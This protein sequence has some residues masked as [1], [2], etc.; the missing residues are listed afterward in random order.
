M[1]IYNLRA[2]INAILRRD[3]HLR[4]SEAPL[5]VY[6]TTTDTAIRDAAFLRTYAE[7]IR[8]GNELL[9]EIPNTRAATLEGIAQRI[10]ARVGQDHDVPSL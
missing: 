10:E 3:K 4:A 5:L 9:W 8:A 6:M 1:T 7:R 2:W